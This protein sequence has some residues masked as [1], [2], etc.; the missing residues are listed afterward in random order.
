MTATP[1]PP[2]WDFDVVLADGGTVHI[3]PILPSDTEAYLRFFHRLSRE[4]RYYRFFSPKSEL[5]DDEVRFFTTV[6]F[7]ARVALVAVVG[8]EIIAVARYDRLDDRPVGEVGPDAE[9]AFTI[10]DHHQGRGLGTVMLEYLAAAGRENGIG[11]F[12]AQT[13]PDNRRMIRVFHDAGY[14]TVDR[15]ADGV[16][17]VEFPIAS[18]D[19]ARDAVERR[20]HRAEARSIERILRPSSVAVIGASA[21]PDSTG[22]RLFTHLLAGGFAG[23]V[24]PVNPN[25]SH[26][27]SVPAHPDVLAV[28]GEVDLAV[29]ATPA[30]AVA[31]VVA[32]CAEKG[33]MGLVIISTGF[34][35][36]GPEGAERERQVLAAARRGGLRIVGPN[37][38]GVV[39]THLGLHATFVPVQPPRGRLGI[40]SQSG[41][42]GMA[43][44]EW[45]TRRGLGVS[46]FA[47]VGDK[48]DVSG[49]DLLQYWEDDP[50]TAVICLHL[51]SFGNPRKFARIARRVSASKPVVAV[52]SGRRRGA[53]DGGGPDGPVD[54]LFAQTGVVRVD[55]IDELFDVASVLVDQP[56]PR[57]DRVAVVANARG[58]GLLAVDATLA[59]GLRLADLGPEAGGTG[60]LA[61]WA[62]PAASGVLPLPVLAEAA[63]YADAIGR[64]LAD[65]TTDMV[66]VVVT[67]PIGGDHEAIAEAIRAA[68][69]AGD[70]PVVVTHLSASCPPA[71]LLDERDQPRVPVFDSPVAASAA[72]AR[73]AGYADW[74]RREPGPVPEPDGLDRATARRLVDEA[75]A[76]A[77]GEV[78]LDAATARSLLRGYGIA[79]A[80]G[81][82]A[83]DVGGEGV[84]TTV[85]VVQDRAFGP[86]VTLAMGGEVAELV[87]DRASRIVPLTER[88]AA[89]LV[90]SLRLAPLLLGHRG[91]P[92]LAVDRLEDLLV[93]VGVV[94]DE[95][96]EVVELHL[97]PVAATAR[98]VEI[99][100]A[101]VVLRR[102][103][104]GLPELV[105]RL[106][107]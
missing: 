75:L 26:V 73:V 9:V 89:E 40:Q 28:P 82:D 85:S 104:P 7:E 107:T 8:G 30:E 102:P 32:Q 60:E 19:A 46:S 88:D 1:F 23:P 84:V 17:E 57:G 36:T 51:E 77:D 4:T 70:K 96:P 3:R 41:A 12:V 86:L 48:A 27:A 61:A 83:R 29:I 15:F 90:R 2:H 24:H 54:A 38:M 87:G 97:A 45:A 69:S 103:T 5:T 56:L 31:G 52:K 37:S 39:N 6:D 47:S 72:L 11:R 63:Q 14:Q 16:V 53:P 66:H 98:A 80:A 44:L 68:A 76:G 93:R 101:H 21:D 20:E 67:P 13:L 35:E 95:L 99:G 81:T 22:Y 78:V 62:V 42:V 10:D 33:V 100:E 25:T 49:N 34:A 106:R 59:A 91:S 55:T 58:V 64:V 50:D 105:R 18:T 43:L 92:P 94:A 79:V 74:R 65:D 71:A